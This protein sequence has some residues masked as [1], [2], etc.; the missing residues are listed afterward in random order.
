MQDRLEKEKMFHNEAF[1]KGIRKPLDAYYTIFERIRRDFREKLDACAPGQDVLECGCGVNSYAYDLALHVN[2]L[3]GIDISDE[4]VHQSAAR[5]KKLGLR[6][7]D[8]SI[9]NAEALEY[10]DSLFDLVFG[11]GIIH[12]LDLPVFFGEA[13]RVLRPEGKMIFMEP[14][15]YNPFLNI[16]RKFTPGL[17]TPDEHPLLRKD[18]RLV[19]R[20][21]EE[22][23]IHYYH[24]FTLLAVPFRRKTLFGGLLKLLEKVDDFFFRYIPGFKYL[25]WY[26]I[27]E[28]RFPRKQQG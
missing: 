18:L 23:D 7:C 20:Y 3:C 17:R 28:G 11:V 6:N 13:A 5:A 26:T 25:A 19:G 21:F 14:L 8:F 4:A 9:M 10:G 22:V 27:I 24:F 2:R 12:H 15:G 16:Y 1:A